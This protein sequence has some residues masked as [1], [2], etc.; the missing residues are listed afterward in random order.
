[1]PRIPTAIYAVLICFHLSSSLHAQIEDP[2]LIDQI[3]AEN[4]NLSELYQDYPNAM[5]IY[6]D[7]RKDRLDGVLKQ[8]LGTGLFVAGGYLIFRGIFKSGPDGS[9][10]ID[11]PDFTTAQRI[12]SISFGAIV[13]FAGV[14][15]SSSGSEDFSS[16]NARKR[17]S[18]QQYI[19]DSGYKNKNTDLGYLSIGYGGDGCILRYTF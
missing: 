15:V 3:L 18:V 5:R 9:N 6:R 1:M 4:R 12:G 14:S 17:G 7:A 13:T 11:L 16:A 19:W 2:L 8:A 10:T